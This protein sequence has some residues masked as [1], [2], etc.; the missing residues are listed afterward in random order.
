VCLPGWIFGSEKL[1]ETCESKTPK[2]I[3]FVKLLALML[4]VAS[5]MFLV[6]RI[7]LQAKAKA[8]QSQ[9]D[10]YGTEVII[11]GDNSAVVAPLHVYL[12]VRPV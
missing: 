1:C 2:L 6:R 3:D 11:V 7:A 9:R 5:L 8:E 12:K 10:E 4:V